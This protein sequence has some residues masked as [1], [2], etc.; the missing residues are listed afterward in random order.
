VNPFKNIYQTHQISILIFSFII[1]TAYPYS[2][3]LQTGQ[4]RPI[5]NLLLPGLTNRT[6]SAMITVIAVPVR[7]FSRSQLS[8]SGTPFS[9]SQFALKST[10]P[11][12]KIAPISPI[13][14]IFLIPKLIIRP[15][16]IGSFYSNIAQMN[17]ERKPPKRF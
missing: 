15:F 16:K 4:L 17:T 8:F 5:P 12:R 2:R 14:M 11:A 1:I 13:M 6:N 10:F 9:D 3:L 7:K